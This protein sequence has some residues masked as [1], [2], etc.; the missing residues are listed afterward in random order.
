MKVEEALADAMAASVSEV[1]APPTMGA[2]VRRK[3]R[4]HVIRFRMAGAVMATAVLAAGAPV[5]QAVTAGPEPSGV[6]NS[7]VRVVTQVTVPDVMNMTFEEAQ[8]ALRAADL[9]GEKVSGTEKV[10]LQSPKAGADVAPGSTVRLFLRVTERNELGL[11]GDGRTFGGITLDYLPDDLSWGKSSN[12]WEG[13]SGGTTYTTTYDL[14]D[15]PNGYYGI[16]VFVHEGRTAERVDALLQ[17]DAVEH[18]DIGGK[19]GYLADVKADSDYGRLGA[20]PREESCCTPTLGFRVTDKLAV[21]VAMNPSRAR[22]LSNEEIAA[23]L[24]KIAEGVRSS[25]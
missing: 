17:R 25:K 19:K 2:G 6:A 14:P 8:A 7:T 18:V 23:E 5:Y 11:L 1:K 22:K 15:E 20:Q 24:K 4:G 9:V 12:K 21:E 16:Q 13:R 3:H 10:G